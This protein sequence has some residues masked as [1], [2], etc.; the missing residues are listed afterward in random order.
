MSTSSTIAASSTSSTSS[1]SITTQPPSRKSTSDLT[2]GQVTG[3]GCA[4]A[5][6][7]LMLLSGAGLLYV[8][9]AG[10]D[11]EKLDGLKLTGEDKVFNG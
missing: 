2:N 4:L 6:G 10:N 9:L 7:T 1:P 8:M 3:V 5:V 11:E